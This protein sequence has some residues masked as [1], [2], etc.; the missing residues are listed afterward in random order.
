MAQKPTKHAIEVAW[1]AGGHYSQAVKVGTHLF[2]AGQTASLA[3]AD[4]KAADVADQ[5]AA[6]I[7][8]IAQILD[9]VGGSLGDVV[10]TTCFLADIRDFGTFNKVYSEHFVSDPAPA[11][12]TVQVGAFPDGILVEIEAIAV[13]SSEL[14]N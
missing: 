1:P 6:C 11:R 4:L 13:L 14:A 7:D 12:S 5:T 3:L 8:R 2:I 9:S 10:K